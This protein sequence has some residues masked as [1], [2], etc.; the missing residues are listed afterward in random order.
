[1]FQNPFIIFA[2]V[3]LVLS[4]TFTYSAHNVIKNDIHIS[5]EQNISFYCQNGTSQTCCS[6]L[7]HRVSNDNHS[8]CI[9]IVLKNNSGYNMTLE[10]INLEDGRWI[11]SQDY[12]GSKTVNIN[13]Q[14]RS[15]PV[16]ETETFSSVTS[17]FLGGLAGYVSFIIHDNMMSKFTISWK[18]P[19][20]GSSQYE[21]NFLNKP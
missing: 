13:C 11:N 8:R 16:N 7:A 17:H 6:Q 1:M 5:E 2:I 14:P 3:I 21:V 15:L 9:S 18:V 4:S 20:I 12:G 19:L 10:A